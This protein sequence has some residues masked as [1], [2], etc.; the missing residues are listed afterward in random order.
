MTQGPTTLRT[1]GT[2]V[3]VARLAGKD[4]FDPIGDKVGR[5]HDVVSII[6]FSGQPQVVGLVVEVSSRHR[7]FVSLSR[8]TSV[9]SGA[10][11]TTGLLNMRRFNQRAVETL[12]VSQLFDR[13]VQMRDGSGPVRIRDVGIE[14][15]MPREWR[16]T[17]LFVERVRRSTLGFKRAGETLMVELNQV[18]SLAAQMGTQDATSM[19]AY[20][21][22]LKPADLADLLHDLPEARML[23]VATQLTDERLA[24]VLEELGESHSVAIL[25]SLDGKRAADILELMQPD[26]AADLIGEMKPD[27]ADELL[28][29]MEPDEAADVRRLMKYEDYTAGG[30]MT[31]EPVILPPDATV[32]QLL[33]SVRRQDIPPALAAMTI[34]VRPPLETPT[35]KLLGVVHTQRALREPPQTLLGT[36][37]DTD[38]EL[39]EPDASIGTITRLLATYNLT[40]LPVVDENKHLLGAV[41]VDDVLDHLLPDDWRDQEDE[42]TDAEMEER[43]DV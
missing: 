40:A 43:Y 14:Q 26:D 34:V 16:I 42:V 5:V 6:P 36:I 18:S 2:R 4:V 9:E 10:V 19:I 32:A 28:S 20:T 15:T 29:L 27:T 31:T 24:D 37:L 7:I 22:D 11:I 13:V 30:L 23:E 3:F 33:A 17:S 41:S 8:V 12:V 35:G 1:K 38:I 39:V 21:E 25:E